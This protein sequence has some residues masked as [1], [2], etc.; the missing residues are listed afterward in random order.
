MSGRPQ[1]LAAQ[2][3]AADPEASVWV[4]ASAGTGKTHVLTNRVLR[5]LLAGS[6]P[7]RILCL[8]FT[9]AAA[10]EMSIRIAGTLGAWTA[11]DDDELTQTLLEL[12][13]EPP[14]ADN[15]ARARRL[16][17]EVLE[18][19]G[20]L[21]VETIH[22]FCESLLGRFPLEARLAPH[23]QVMDERTADELLAAARERVLAAD[24]AR[25]APLASR[26]AALVD[27]EHLARIK[28]WATAEGEA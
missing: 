24:L 25:P 17:A 4:S 3:A 13:G 12:S 19:P 26:L 10:A 9:K 22:A 6:P 27:Y 20:G 7:E 8:T 23:F 2:A 21:S 18:A 5:L 1:L 28:E 14:S 11:L 15:L 16:F